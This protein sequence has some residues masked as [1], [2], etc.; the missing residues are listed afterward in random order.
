MRQR[1]S[2]TLFWILDALF[3]SL[4]P[5]DLLRDSKQGIEKVLLFV[6]SM[7]T[8]FWQAAC[9]TLTDVLAMSLTTKTDMAFA[10]LWRAD[11]STGL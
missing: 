3:T 5:Q 6:V 11:W 10:R 1:W 2:V 8:G 9:I 4:F 7:I